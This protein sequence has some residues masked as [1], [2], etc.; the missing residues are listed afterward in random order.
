MKYGMNYIDRWLQEYCLHVDLKK[1][2]EA[3][4]AMH[5]RVKLSGLTGI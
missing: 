1:T 3:D 4:V 5:L 2:S